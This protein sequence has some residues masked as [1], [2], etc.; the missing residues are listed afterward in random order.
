M[1]GE[2]RIVVWVPDWSVSSLAASVPPGSPGVTVRG[3]KVVATTRS[4]R[5]RGVRPGMKQAIAEHLCEELLVLPHDPLRDQSAFEVLLGV[6]D[7]YFANVT[8]IV[9]GLAW[10]TLPKRLGGQIQEDAARGE[11]QEA[12]VEETGVECF[13]GIASGIAAGIAAAKRGQNISAEHLDDFLGYLPLSEL[14]AALKVVGADPEGKLDLL[15]TLGIATGKDLRQLGAKQLSARFGKEG[16]TLWKVAQGGDLYV[17]SSGTTAEE[18]SFRY[19]FDEPVINID[20]VILEAR[21]VGQQ[22]VD[23]LVR[24]AVVAQGLEI[25]LLSSDGQEYPRR[26]ALFDTTNPANVTQRLLWQM[27]AWQDHRPPTAVDEDEVFVE[28]GLV[29]ISIR[30]QGLV[31]SGETQVLWGARPRSHLV[32]QTVA[33]VQMLAGEESVK[34]P[35]IQAGMNPR[36]RV[37]MKLWG[38][39]AIKAPEPGPWAGAVTEPPLVLFDKPPRAKLIGKHND[40]TWGEIRIRSRGLLDGEPER[41]IMLESR[42]DLDAGSYLV[43][44]VHS[45]WAQMG[46]WWEVEHTAHGYLRVAVKEEDDFLLVQTRGTWQVEGIYV[47]CQRQRLDHHDLRKSE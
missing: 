13:V 27:R 24:Q 10:A 34:Q 20:Q 22:M 4:A 5:Q 14:L 21:I 40:G 8:A 45:T 25:T 28:A 15:H 2:R 31:G 32:E 47:G 18:I 30:A 12:L 29:A 11:L 17:A 7:R 36:E 43:E 33:Q 37:V 16:E 1:N 41:I 38:E 3:G 26:W 46:R 19:N 35:V 39:E 9:P 42:K 23:R 6:F 44:S